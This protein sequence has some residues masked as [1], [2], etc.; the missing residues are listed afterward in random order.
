ML[1]VTVFL[2]VAAVVG[3]AHAIWQGIAKREE[4]ER[5]L[6]EQ[7]CGKWYLADLNRAYEWA[8]KLHGHLRSIQNALAT[9][10]AFS[11][12]ADC[13]HAKLEGAYSRESNAIDRH[14]DMAGI[15]SGILIQFPGVLSDGLPEAVAKLKKDLGEHSDLL[16]DIAEIVDYDAVHG[17][18]SLPERVRERQDEWRAAQYAAESHKIP[19]Y[20]PKETWACPKCGKKN[21]ASDPQS[22]GLI[23]ERESLFL[24]CAC[25]YSIERIPLDARPRTT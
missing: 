18:R 24:R 17:C 10:A 25:G 1:T 21:D 8:D 9:D 3:W 20:D 5:Y 19:T 12:L 4:H 2:G 22:N 6:V 16:C 15:L 7:H 14:L 11:E 13:V 23:A